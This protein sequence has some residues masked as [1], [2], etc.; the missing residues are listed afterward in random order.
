VELIGAVEF[1]YDPYGLVLANGPQSLTKNNL[2]A[3]PNQI[4]GSDSS[5]AGQ[6]NNSRGL[7]ASAIRLMGR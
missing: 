5:R 1:G 3:L 2:N 7:S 4:A 6:W